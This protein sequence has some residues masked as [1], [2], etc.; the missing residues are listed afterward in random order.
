MK[1]KYCGYN[2]SLEEEYCP[3]CG[4]K[5]EQAAKHIADMEQ[6]KEDYEETKESVI[7]KSTKI[8]SRTAR[9]AI[10][11]LMVFIVAVM[12]I[13]IGNYRDFDKRYDNSR[14]QAAKKAEKYRGDI[15]ATLKEMEEHRDYSAMNYFVLN[16]QLRS[17][18]DYNDYSRVFTAAI[19]YN[20]IYNDILNIIDGFDGYEGKASKEWCD[21]IAI[22]ISDWDSYVGGEF[23]SDSPDS[24]MHAGEHGA[25]LADA[26]K[27]AQ[28][29]V[30]VYFELTDKQA[31]SMWNMS[32]EEIAAMLYNKCQD[33]YPEDKAD[34]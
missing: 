8:N 29:M 20:A 12:L 32:K 5:N 14:K 21:D 13:A 6:Y 23:W 11:A 24:P 33:L 9:I 30:Q 10:L 31:S 18:D 4:N 17:N 19:S 28:D 3:H 25:F 2:I 22:Y 7:S 15:S 1:C 26:K 27:D 34:E 16:H